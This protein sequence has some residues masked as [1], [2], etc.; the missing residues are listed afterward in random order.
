MQK[1]IIIS[2]PSGAGKT[3]IANHI[4]DN[5][6]RLVF[7]VSA[8][9]RLKR[10]DEIDGKHYYFISREQF[11][12]KIEKEEFL[13]WEEVYKGDYYGTLKSEVDKIW[14][15]NQI[16]VFDIDVKGALNVK[17]KYRTNALS[18]FIKPPSKEILLQRLQNRAT[19]NLK[20]F[21]ERINKAESE[22]KYEG[23]FDKVVV[24]D[25]LVR[26]KKEVEE[27]VNN[28]LST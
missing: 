1:L 14:K 23:L 26:T 3:T 15:K 17:E 2:A 18:I 16:V 9:T 8:T 27:I 20:S 4:L 10:K 28:F 7:S 25:D 12:E 19:E 11:K 21:E 24:N 13:E 5:D 22:L 6:Q